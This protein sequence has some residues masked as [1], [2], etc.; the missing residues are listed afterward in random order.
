MEEEK[1]V[2]L[3]DYIDI[4][5]RRKWIILLS[6]VSVLAST[7]YFTF[8]RPPTYEAASILMVEAEEGM[9]LL[10][11]RGSLFGPLAKPVEFFERIMESPSYRDQ[12][13]L[14]VTERLRNPHGILLPMD[15]ALDLVEHNLTLNTSKT[16]DFLEIKAHAD[17]PLLCYL[18][19]AS[20]TEVLK[21]RSRGVDK[22]EAQSVLDFIEDQKIEAQ[23]KLE[24]A[25]K[26]LQLFRER[27][28][29]VGNGEEGGALGKLIELEKELAGV[30]A[31]KELAQA[32]LEAYDLRIAQVLPDK[33]AG[34]RETEGLSR[35]IATLESIR[36]NLVRQP[37]EHHVE[38][39]SLEKKI[40]EKKKKLVESIVQDTDVRS[41]GMQVEIAQ[42][43]ERRTAEELNIF[44]L[45]SQE[46]Y[47]ENLIEQFKAE[48]PSMLENAIELAQLTRARKVYENM[49]NILLEKGE[50]AKIN[51]S[52]G[53]GGVKVVE[54]AR[55]PDEPVPAHSKR[56][57]V[58]G[59]MVGLG[60]GLGIAFA[61]EYMDNTIRTAEDLS[62]TLGL[63]VMGTIPDIQKLENMQRKRSG[64][65]KRK[66]GGE[67]D[68]PGLISRYE[69]KDMVVESYRSLRT[70]LQ[71]ASVDK[72]LKSMLIS[73]PGP[74]EG[75]TLTVANL[76]ISFAEMDKRT[77][78]VDADLRRPRQHKLFGVGKE[79]GLTDYL[80]GTASLEDVI[81]PTEVD[82]LSLIPAGRGSPNTAEMLGSNRMS[83]LIRKLISEHDIVLFDSPPLVPVTDAALLASKM[84][85]ILLVTKY[86]STHK[87]AVHHALEILEKVGAPT[88]GA[89]L[90]DVEVVRRL[91]YYRYYYNNYYYYT[92]HEDEKKEETKA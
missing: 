84:D 77:I 90:N 57:L 39:L 71:F 74:M 27:V 88:I 60:L 63:S 80:V 79:P 87:D 49:Y 5:W 32:N 59:A 19:A 41:S 24:A 11:P 22:E 3:E 61:L 30:Q 6:F 70:N 81:L 48:H 54:K 83:D 34:V 64:K 17:S 20:G 13:A 28:G 29:I 1:Q 46:R 82:H 62:R 78:I 85:G 47:Y 58:L 4:V 37:G 35:E 36:A 75:K 38:V 66:G 12:V 42:L 14:K 89:I 73:S 9:N 31:Q 67:Q 65:K 56:N 92:Y 52:T 76:G 8:T 16:S 21:D 25:E 86:A 53:T 18:L 50:E 33:T 43:Q 2:G 44:V 10:D 7:T 68:D 69:T 26:K 55:E 45:E 91:G 15:E 72:P 40:A 51:A 23:Q